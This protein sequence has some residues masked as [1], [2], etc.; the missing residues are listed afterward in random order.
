[1]IACSCKVVLAST[2]ARSTPGEAY[3]AILDVESLATDGYLSKA[4]QP[5]G[6]LQGSLIEHYIGMRYGN[7]E[8][9]IDGAINYT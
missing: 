9:A 4:V 7:P 3:A 2:P 8:N 6:P 5:Q 1:L